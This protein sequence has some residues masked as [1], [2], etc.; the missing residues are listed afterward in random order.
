[1]HKYH[2]SD[3]LCRVHIIPIPNPVYWVF[4]S[5]QSL[6]T[7]YAAMTVSI[8]PCALMQHITT[9]H[10]STYPTIGSSATNPALRSLAPA[11][12]QRT[13]AACAGG[14]SS[15]SMN[16]HSSPVSFWN[17]MLSHRLVLFWLWGWCGVLKRIQVLVVTDTAPAPRSRAHV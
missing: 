14:G 16:F 6:A 9:I 17:R 8:Y 10:T 1:M 12:S 11:P 7:A 3:R 2:R 13:P 15:G 4:I 5:A